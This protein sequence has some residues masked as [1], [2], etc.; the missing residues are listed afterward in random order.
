MGAFIA[1]KPIP[2]E[3]KSQTDSS[4]HDLRERSG[5]ASGELKTSIFVY[6]A[7]SVPLTAISLPKIARGSLRLSSSWATDINC[8]SRYPE[9]I[10]ALKIGAA[11][12]S[13]CPDASA[14]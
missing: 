3:H 2:T 7:L 13:V 8:H 1:L 14:T 12:G 9:G 6:V 10:F 4:S 11:F 5:V